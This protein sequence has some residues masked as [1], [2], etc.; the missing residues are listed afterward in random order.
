MMNR[1]ERLLATQELSAL[2]HEYWHDVDTNWGRNA[3][4]YYTD[5]A[6]FVGPEASYKG[7]EKIRQFYQWREKR[8]K[9]VAVH[10]VNNFRVVFEDDNHVTCTWY[11]IL[12]A[13]DGEV[14]L[15]TH[16]PITISLVTDRAER[17]ADGRW[18]YTYR[19]FVTWFQGGTP[20]TNPNLDDK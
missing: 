11:L 7:K 8:G 17:G 5:D 3:P 12:Y 6:L 4:D 18:L 9:R 14:V 19:Q 16:A 15:P 1:T 13:A 2:L 10:A 20:P